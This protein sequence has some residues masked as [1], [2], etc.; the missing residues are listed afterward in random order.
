MLPYWD[1]GYVTKIERAFQAG[2]F[3]PNLEEMGEWG[4]TEESEGQTCF[5]LEFCFTKYERR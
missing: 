1:T 2:N 4:R 3:F 5:D